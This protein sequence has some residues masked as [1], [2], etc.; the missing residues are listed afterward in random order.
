[1]DVVAKNR[2]K[3]SEQ[4]A[5]H[6]GQRL[7]ALRKRAGLTQ[8]ALGEALDLDYQA[9]SRMERGGVVPNWSTVKRLAGA[10]KAS[11]NDF[12]TLKE[13]NASGLDV[14]DYIPDTADDE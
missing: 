9:V 5:K 12:L 6:F 8:A 2:D 10:V 7:K 1:M 13:W 11:P 3:A 14:S 4:D